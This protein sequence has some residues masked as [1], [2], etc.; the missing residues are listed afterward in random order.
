MPE[1]P[2]D[3]S[4]DF[5]IIGCDEAGYGSWA[6]PLVA[7]VVIA[8]AGWCGSPRIRDSKDLTEKRRKL[9]FDELMADPSINWLWRFSDSVEID[10]KGVYVCLCQMHTANVAWAQALMKESHPGSTMAIVDGNLKIEGARSIHK[11][12]SFIPAVS[13]ASIIAK[14]IQSEMMIE[15]GKL[16]PEYGFEQHK[17]Y[18]GDDAHQHTRALQAHGP[19]SIHRRSYEPVAR[20]LRERSVDEPLLSWEVDL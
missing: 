16:Y 3:P 18:G 2:Y 5:H 12:D 6:G 1:L 4:S 11:A 8:P 15:M 20:V 7:A 14:T 10:A 9:A 17:G 13:A 19:C